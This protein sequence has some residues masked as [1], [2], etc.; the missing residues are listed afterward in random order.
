MK[1]PVSLGRDVAGRYWRAQHAGLVGQDSALTASCA[2]RSIAYHTLG[3]SLNGVAHGL[4]TQNV[5]LRRQ[6]FLRFG[7]EAFALPLARQLVRAKILNQRAL[8]RR[9]ARGNLNAALAELQNLASATATAPNR[10]VL[11]GLEGRAA[12]VYFTMLAEALREQLKP[13][14]ALEGR[15]RRP[16][17]DPV[18]A[19][20]S[21]G[22]SLLLR[23]AW[24]AVAGVGM[25]PI[26]GFF[27]V[28]RPGRPALALDLMEPFRPLIA[29]SLLLRVVNSREIRESHFVSALG[30]V[31]LSD[32]G[33]KSFVGAY[34]RR[35]NEAVTHPLFGYRISYRRV[36]ELEARIIARVLTG[37]LTDIAPLVTR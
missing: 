36:L 23:D 25:D 7:D 10:N 15:N 13:A 19:L 2:G 6:R 12:R 24:S 8:L 35:L 26:Y 20:L 1:T 11:M 4:A 27:H 31:Y 5:D 33:R 17:R 3:G 29:D 14:F 21:F 37:E 28:L 30:G 18:N 9:N 16:P 22:Y 32:A 34:E